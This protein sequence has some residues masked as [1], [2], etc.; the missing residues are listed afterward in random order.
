[1]DYFLFESVF[2]LFA[3]ETPFLTGAMSSLS[4]HLRKVEGS[5]VTKTFNTELA[6]FC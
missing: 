4:S 6:H 1:M 5:V 3:Q 2:H